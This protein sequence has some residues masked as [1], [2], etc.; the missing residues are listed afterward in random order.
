MR[1][2]HY[3]PLPPARTGIA[4]YSAALLEYLGHLAE[5]ETIASAAQAAGGNHRDAAA[6]YQLGNNP[7]HDFV[8]EAAIRHPGVAVLHE[9]NLHHLIVHLTLARGKADSYWR[10]VALNG[11]ALGNAPDYK[12]RMLRTV[13]TRS[14]AAIVHSTEVEN[15]LRAQGFDRPIQRIPHG[16]W[17]FKAEEHIRLRAEYRAKLGFDESTP[18]FGIFGFLKSYK[19]IA[20]AQRAFRRLVRQVPNA[21]LLLVGERHP[22]VLLDRSAHVRHIDFAPIADFNGYMAAC[23]AIVNL[24]YPT[25]GETSGTLTRAMAMGKPAIVTETGSFREYPEHTC[26][27]VRADPS[28]EE[29]LFEYMMLLAQRSDVREA[30]GTRAREWMERNCS[31]QSVAEQYAGF[32]AD[33]SGEHIRRWVP[34]SDTYEEVHQTRL[35]KTLAI[36]PPG[37]PNDTVLEMGA[38]FHLTPALKSRLGYG[39]VQGCYLGAPGRTDHRSVTAED[40]ESFTCAVDHFD[41]ERDMFPYE[42]AAFATVLCCEL[43]EHLQADP[44]HM[45][46]EIHRILKPGGCLVLTTPNIASLR[47]VASLLQGFHPM[48]FPAYLHPEKR[49]EA[50][51]AREYTPGE[52]SAL[53][54]NSGFEVTLLETGPFKERPQPDLGWVRHLLERHDLRRD[55]AGECIYAVGRK[56]TTVGSRYPEWLYA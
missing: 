32:V 46:A 47:S 1:I 6:V 51:H 24:R 54:E 18:V 38:Y 5:V 36:T 23:D 11:G 9:A 22:E 31:W 17:K 10:E 39:Q 33:V 40:G 34:V 13:L 20:Q 19:R 48:L 7:H 27:R 42:D 44:M 15:V 28:E 30:I 16:A 52:I 53:L 4:D 55:H 3:S 35:E 14:R 37:G 8:Y 12:I 49:D 56:V 43:L 29:L 26:L 41:A 50:R 25:V 2:A 45:M 21:K